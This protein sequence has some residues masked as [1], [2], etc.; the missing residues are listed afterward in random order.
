MRD[1]VVSRAE[2]VKQIISVFER[3]TIFL[4]FAF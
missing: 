3:L 2:I 4:V 1:K